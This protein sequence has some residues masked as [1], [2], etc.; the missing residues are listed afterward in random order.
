[1]TRGKH[2]TAWLDTGVLCLSLVSV[3]A[4][5]P[6]ASTV[7][8][9]LGPLAIAERDAQAQA[10]ASRR[11]SEARPERRKRAASVAAATP[12]ARPEPPKAAA[13]PTVPDKDAPANADAPAST[14]V[15]FEG[16]YAGADIAVFRWAGSPEQ[17]QRDDKAKIRIEPASGGNVGIT[18]INSEDGSDLCELLARVDGNA[19][20]IESTQPCFGDGNEGSPE[21]QLTSGRA[22]LKGDRLSMNAEGTISLALPDQ[23]LDGEITYTF[24]GE[25]Q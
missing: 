8:L 9:G 1:M 5:A 3:L 20:L 6:R 10:E 16:L 17:E 19:A 21:A 7:P 22:V 15:R 11:K 14:A 4:C 13:T 2:G 23:E 12:L 24:E 25:R 18:L